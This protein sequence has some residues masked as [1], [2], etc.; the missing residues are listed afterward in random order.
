MTVLARLATVVRTR[1]LPAAISIVLIGATLWPLVRQPVDDDFP[2]STYPMFAFERPTRMTM[3]YAVGITRT[4]RRYLRPEIVGTPEVLQAR[5]IIERG[6]GGTARERM[7]LC[8][9]IATTLREVSEFD[10]V[11]AI[12][13]VT[14]T[15]DA[16]DFLIRGQIGTEIERVRCEVK[17]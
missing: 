5:A 2:L 9:Q 6:I 15:H 14:G 4:G 1:A 10:D 11:V 8:S 16:L 13:I 3:S 7:A 12:A 17:R